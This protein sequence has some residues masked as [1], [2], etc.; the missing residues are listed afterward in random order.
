MSYSWGDSSGI[1][2]GQTPGIDYGG[3]F[4]LPGLSGAGALASGSGGG[5]GGGSGF[6]KGLKFLTDFAD[7][8]FGQSSK[9][10]DKAYYDAEK[11]RERLSEGQK[12][13]FDN[14]AIYTPP[15][16]NPG[17]W[18]GGGGA[19]QPST[20]DRIGGAALSAGKGALAGASLGPIGAISGAIVGGLGGLFG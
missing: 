18:Y 1:D 19:A 17:A 5:S 8:E 11:R 12:Q 2:W 16:Y 3:D 20:A 10:R 6:L 4:A 9:Y 13:I 7:K 14:F 15:G